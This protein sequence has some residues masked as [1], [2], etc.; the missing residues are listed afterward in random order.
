[1]TKCTGGVKERF[2][3]NQLPNFHIAENHSL[4][5]MHDLFEG[6]ASDTIGKVLTN[7][8]CVTKIISLETLNYRI[9]TFDYGELEKSA[10]PRPLT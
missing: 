9:S 2:I 8:V 10:K 3:F 6:V 5:L 7:L 4:D 1:M